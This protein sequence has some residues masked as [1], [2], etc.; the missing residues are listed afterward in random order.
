[1]CLCVLQRYL[2][3][4]VVLGHMYECT[5]V[6]LG[7]MCC[8]H[9]VVGQGIVVRGYPKG[10][11]VVWAHNWMGT[12]LFGHLF[13]GVFFIPTSRCHRIMLLDACTHGC[14]PHCD[15]LSPG[16]SLLGCA[17]GCVCACLCVCLCVL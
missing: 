10:Y 12:S 3:G 16:M 13:L 17:V 4:Y 9:I 5:H 8:R 14:M 1:M 15:I 7:I 11:S 2:I 6:L